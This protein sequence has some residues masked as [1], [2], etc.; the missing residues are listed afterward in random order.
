[1][2]YLHNLNHLTPKAA[3]VESVPLIREIK[4][5]VGYPLTDL[6]LREHLSSFFA[7]ED[8]LNK[9]ELALLLVE[10]TLEQVAALAAEKNEELHELAS[11][12]RAKQILEEV[13]PAMDQNLQFARVINE[14]QNLFFQEA[15]EIFNALPKLRM[16]EEKIAYNER[17]NEIF[18][19]ILRNKEFAFNFWDLVH[20]AHVSHVD[21]LIESLNK[22]FIFHFTL[23]EELQ[24]L[25]F[26]QIRHRISGSRI[27]EVEKI[28]RNVMAINNGVQRAYNFNRKM[29]DLSVYLYS[30]IKW[31]SQPML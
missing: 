2:L 17:L 29:V 11:L 19:M 23:E 24:K 7:T 10:P 4:Q 30:Y 9:M 27:E 21:G 12:V 14:W 5:K 18:R 28:K 1:M 16:Q 8:D 6:K 25:S 31:L 15:V 22:G 3:D 26:E 20:E 13:P